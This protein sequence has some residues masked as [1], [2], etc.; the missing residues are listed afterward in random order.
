MLRFNTTINNLE[1]YD[2]AIWQTAGGG[3]FT[4]ITD[5]QFSGN[6][7]GGYGNVDGTNTTFTIQG[8][9][10]TAGTIVSIN[11]VIQFPVL[12][13]AVTGT[14]LEF[15]EPPAPDDVIDVRVLT[16]TTIVS[17]VSSDN[18]LQQLIVSDDAVE[19]WTGTSSSTK[20]LQIN[21]V[22][23]VEYLTGGKTT[24]TQTPINIAANNTPYV[25]STWSQ[26][27]FV[28]AKYV[29]SAKK[30]TSNFQS[31][32]AIVTTDQAGNAYI[33]TYA[34]VNNGVDMGALTA[35]VVGGNVQ[36]Y[37][38]TTTNVTNANVKVMGTYIV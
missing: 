28:T 4:V 31:M 29:I 24:Y 11:G 18:G 7:G 13:Y 34:I 35:N 26:T 37:W 3:I 17:A 16:T 20:Q 21:Q 5:R 9:S 1:F 23:D 36:V 6:V 27:A 22:G 32:E 14:T 8:N 10:T 33:S 2:G 30:G 15:T 38:T 19:I 25:I 12:A